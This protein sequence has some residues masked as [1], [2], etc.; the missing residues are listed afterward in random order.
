MTQPNLD[1]FLRDQVAAV[2]G[3]A[4]ERVTVCHGESGVFYRVNISPSPAYP[5]AE[6]PKGQQGT[7]L[8]YPPVPCN[9]L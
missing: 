2:V 3:C 6:A 4:P 5:A 8:V 9:P 1:G 7:S